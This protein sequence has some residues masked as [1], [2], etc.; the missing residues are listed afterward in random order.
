MA[1]QSVKEK[2]VEKNQTEVHTDVD[3]NIYADS[4]NNIDYDL[5][6]VMVLRK[7]RKI[8]HKKKSARKKLL[9]DLGVL[10]I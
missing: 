6:D 8:K 5:L 2:N 7:G 10:L 9:P 1:M 4:N 3:S